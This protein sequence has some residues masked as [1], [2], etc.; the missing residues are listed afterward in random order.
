MKIAIIAA[1]GQAGQVLT[2]EAVERGHQVTAIVRSENKS[3]AQEV[4]QKDALALTKEDLASF[5]LVINAFGAWTAETLPQHSQL[6]EHLTTLL[7]TSPTRLLIVGGAGSLFLDE[8]GQLALKD[9]SDFP[10]EYLP[11]AEAMGEGLA[12]YRRAQDVNW[13]YLSPAADFDAT[14]EKTGVYTLAGEIF[15]VNAKGESYISYRDYALALLD[16]A[17]NS[18]HNQVRLS[19]LGQ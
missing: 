10:A 3:Q 19:V 17:E 5:D 2:Q 7:A 15:Q 11:I 14:G 1:N 13:L 8:T 9:S 4:I 6:A 18:E 16:L 12:I